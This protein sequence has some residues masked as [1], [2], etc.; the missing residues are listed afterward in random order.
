MGVISDYE[1]QP[2]L[3]RSHHGRYAIVTVGRIENLDALAGQDP[4]AAGH[5]LRGDAAATRSTPPSWWPR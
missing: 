3:I 5:A 1:D 2:L 4:D